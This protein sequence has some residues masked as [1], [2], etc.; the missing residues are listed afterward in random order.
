MKA[1]SLI[2]RLL[3]KSDQVVCAKAVAKATTSAKRTAPVATPRWRFM[4]GHLKER[5]RAL[6]QQ[7]VEKL[8]KER[9]R[10][11]TPP[12]KQ[13]ASQSSKIADV[14]ISKAAAMAKASTDMASEFN[15]RFQR[16]QTVL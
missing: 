8:Q 11:P 6:I 16:S 9:E 14:T 7:A 15:S 5:R 4:Q 13:Q 1:G 3:A 12:W 2:G 10:S